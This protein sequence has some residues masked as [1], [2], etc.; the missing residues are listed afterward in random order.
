MHRKTGMVVPYH[1]T[2]PLQHNLFTSYVTFTT[3]HLSYGLY[4]GIMKVPLQK[5]LMSR[6]A[7]SSFVTFGAKQTP[8]SSEAYLSFSFKKI[9]KDPKDLPSLFVLLHSS[10]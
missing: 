1:F 4:G 9:K 5:K 8:Q 3:H 10:T 6:G 2:T 7:P